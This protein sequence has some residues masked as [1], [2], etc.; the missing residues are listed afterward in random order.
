MSANVAVLGAS[1]FIGGAV[2]D[3]L[4]RRGARPVPVVAPRVTT[5]ARTREDLQTEQRP[6][7]VDLLDR[8]L[9]NVDVVVNAAGMPQAVSSSDDA[10][11]GANALLPL[12]VARTLST[13]HPAV[14][15][16]H[17]S[18]AAV[19]GRRAVLDESV[20][21]APF[22]PYSAS[23]AL[24]EQCLVD[25]SDVVIFR[26]TSVHGR[27][28]EVTRRLV[29]VLRSPLASVAGRGDAPTPQVLVENVADAVAFVALREQHL[30][31]VVLQP[32][33]QLTVGE[34]AR[35]VAGREPR[36]LPVG[37]ARALVAAL[38]WSGRWSGR[39]SGTGRRLEMLWFGQDQESGWLDSTDW[40]PVL[41]PE[42]WSRLS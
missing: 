8:E 16:V 14:R 34:L 35:V 41:G 31:S 26:P 12:L 10:L 5:S 36:H 6:E 7:C 4:A 20:T 33:E 39:V 15:L 21:L 18:S 38:M 40:Q 1:G 19:Q 24:A 2:R 25:F 37:P 32:S 29:S 3:A 28:R 42:G 17:I 30:P 13:R 11:F 23:K 27:G 9:A 22:S